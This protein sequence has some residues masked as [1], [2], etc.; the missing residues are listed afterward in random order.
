MFYQTSLSLSQQE[1][2]DT[3]RIQFKMEKLGKKLA[4]K[5]IYTDGLSLWLKKEKDGKL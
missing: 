5:R 4:L 3:R 1:N 2:E